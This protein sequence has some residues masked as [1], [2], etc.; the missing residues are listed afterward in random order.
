MDQFL[1][2]KTL[3]LLVLSLNLRALSFVLSALSFKMQS[4]N[5]LNKSI[6]RLNK[7]KLY[8]T[9]FQGSYSTFVLCKYVVQQPMQWMS[10]NG[11]QLA[12]KEQ[13]LRFSS[14]YIVCQKPRL[15]W[16]Q[17]VKDWSS[18]TGTIKGHNIISVIPVHMC[19]VADFK[20]ACFYSLKV[21]T[22]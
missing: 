11:E 4:I 21:K 1:I 12:V 17:K 19:A 3:R 20:N 5:L 10:L 15:K 16:S 7:E 8:F 13:G 14:T 6:T 22:L 9:L 2:F 18:L